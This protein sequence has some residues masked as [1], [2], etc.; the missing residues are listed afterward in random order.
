MARPPRDPGPERAVQFVNRLTH[1]KGVWAGTPFRLRPWQESEIIRPLFRTREDGLRAIRTCLLMMPRKNGKTELLAALALYCLLGDGEQGAEVY[2]AAADRE[3]A[4]IAFGVAAQMVKND[5][6]LYSLV[7]L[8]ESQKRIVHPASGSFY[9]AISSEA[10]SKHGFNASHLLY[11]ELHAA[12]SRDLWDVLTS[13]QG[14]R[15]QPLTLAVSTAG[16]DRHSILWELYQHALAVRANPALDPTFLSIIYEAPLEADWQDPAVWAAANPALGDFRSLE[17]MQI[18]AAR[19]RVIPAQENNFRRLF[20]NQWTDQAKKWISSEAWAACK[21]PIDWAAYAGRECYVG[22]DLS[23]T[24]DL[25]ALTAIFPDEEGGAGFAVLP[26]AFCPKETIDRRVQTDRVPYDVWAAAGH[27]EATRGASV[28]YEAVHERL[29]VWDRLYRIRQIAYDPWNATSLVQTLQDEGFPCVPVRQGF[30][31]L[32]DP[33][34]AYERSI[35]ARELRHDGHPVLESHVHKCAAE[36]DASG[37]IRP[38]KRASTDRI[39][40]V[41]ALICA[42]Y[43]WL[44]EPGG[45]PSAYADHPVMVV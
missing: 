34:K 40:L 29:R 22:M 4:G 3:Q 32:N 1:T 35:V 8:V 20:L 26:H 7:Q 16:Y 25:T 17:D 24:T 18:A 44:K 39:D 23:T 27:L 6:H 36:T 11:D 2:S 30:S 33:S 45:P 5:P 12:Q 28:D 37:N 43:A 31:T 41:V 42:L 9:R 13:S 19:A 10:Y 15:A 14:A 38:S 21:V